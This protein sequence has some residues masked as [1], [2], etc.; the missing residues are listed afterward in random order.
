MSASKQVTKCLKY[1]EKLNFL[2][3][4]ISVFAIINLYVIGKFYFQEKFSSL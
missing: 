1:L 4:I 3:I 2:D